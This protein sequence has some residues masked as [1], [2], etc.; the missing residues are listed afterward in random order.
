[1]HQNKAEMKL[2]CL[3][4]HSLAL[5]QLHW[6][7]WYCRDI[8][9][10]WG[11]GKAQPDVEL[12]SPVTSH[13]FWARCNKDSE[14]CLKLACH[15]FLH[16]LLLSCLKFMIFFHLSSRSHVRFNTLISR[17]VGFVY[18]AAGAPVNLPAVNLMASFALNCMS[19]ITA[20]DNLAITTTWWIDQASK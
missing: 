17:V 12:M 11:K 7:P 4:L 20:S 10:L 8:Q 5:V 2:L 14:H 9:V 19:S 18:V 1:M 3:I 6:H 15:N 16:F 13:V